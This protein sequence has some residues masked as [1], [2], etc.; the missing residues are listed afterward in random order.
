MLI[1]DDVYLENY[2]RRIMRCDFPHGLSRIN[3]YHLYEIVL[4]GQYRLEVS[5]I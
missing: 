1:F 2:L 4:A 3:Q 5:S